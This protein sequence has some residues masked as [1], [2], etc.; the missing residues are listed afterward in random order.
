MLWHYYFITVSNFF[1][2]WW[3]NFD[4]HQNKELQQV[5]T[6]AIAR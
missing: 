1:W 3:R 4:V 5:H 6:V 2:H